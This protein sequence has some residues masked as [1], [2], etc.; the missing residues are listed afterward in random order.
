[1]LVR[2]KAIIGIRANDEPEEDEDELDKDGEPS[3]RRSAHSGPLGDLAKLGWMA[4]GMCR[5]VPGIEF[6]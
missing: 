4:A 5:R 1:L 3:T 6:M 2:V